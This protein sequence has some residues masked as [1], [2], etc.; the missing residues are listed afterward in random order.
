MR[1]RKTPDQEWED[2]WKEI[3]THPDGSL[4]LDQIKKE[5]SDF[6]FMIREV[7]K[8]YCEITGNRLS[9]PMYYA[10]TVLRAHD[11][12]LEEQEAEQIE[13]DNKDGECS[14]CGQEI[15]MRDE[16]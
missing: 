8:V 2:H 15:E 9:K 10:N 3:C 12:Y 1:T 13:E 5:L 14:W 7:P 6:S 4:N 16:E 11:D